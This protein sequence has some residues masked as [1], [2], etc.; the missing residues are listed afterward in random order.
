MALSKIASFNDITMSFNVH[1]VEIP[2]LNEGE[3]LVRNIYTTICRS[4][5]YTF[6]GKRKEKSPTILG[7]EIVG[8]I[9]DAA[10]EPGVVD[11][12]GVSLKKGDRIT[13]GIYASNPIS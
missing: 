2:S 6:E 11:I 8:T 7:H 13:W 12:R 9:I 3:L 10:D 4:D 5:I 1:D